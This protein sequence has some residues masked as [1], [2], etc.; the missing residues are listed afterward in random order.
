MIDAPGTRARIYLV[1]DLRV[2]VGRQSVSRADHDV[3]LPNLSFQLLLALIEAAPNVLSVDSLMAR[4][5]PGQV[6]SP[7]TINKRAKLLR[8]ALG[9]NAREPRYF[10]GVRSR[11]Y[12][13]IAPVS[14]VTDGLPESRVAHGQSAVPAIE[15]AEPVR[16]VFPQRRAARIAAAVLL[17]VCGMVSLRS[18]R[19]HHEPA[20]DA[21]ARVV[22]VS[23]L[24]FQN[25]SADADDAYFSLGVPEMI[26]SRV[27]QIRGLTVL[28]RS[29]SFAVPR[30]LSAREIGRRLN[31]RYLVT[32]S[33]QRESQRL[34][35]LV[36]LIEAESGT[37]IWS[38]RYDRRIGEIFDVEEK[39]ADQVSDALAMRNVGGGLPP[40]RQERSVNVQAYL[41]YLRGRSLLNRFTAPETEAAIPLFEQSIALDGAFAPSKAALYDA[42]MQA[43]DTQGEDLVPLRRQYNDLIEQALATDPQCG[44][45]YI[46]R[47]MWGSD[48]PH[49]RALD[50]Q[51]GLE[52]DPSNGRG[53]TA[54]AFFL[55][56]FDPDALPGEDV[57]ALQR[58]LLIDPMSAQARFLDAAW[59][60]AAGEMKSAVVEEKLLQ[61]LELDPNFVPAL[62]RYGKYR[63][64]FDG[65]IAEGLGYEEH[66]IA[67]DPKNPWSRLHAMAM[68]LDL[69]EEAAAR[70]VVAG[71]AKSAAL[72]P[73]MLALHAGDRR[74]AGLA[75]FDQSAFAHN[76]YENWGAPEALR[77]Y[78]L[79]GGEYEK[80]ISFLRQVYQMG[81]SSSIWLMTFRPALYVSQLLAAEGRH[82][83]ALELKRAVVAWNDS[84]QAKFGT[85]YARRLRAGI[86]MEEGNRVAALKELEASFRAYDYEFWWYTLE[87]DPIWQPAHDD[88][89][90]RAI[91]REVRQY[92]SLQHDEL[93]K[94][95][96][97]G[98]VPLRGH[99]SAVR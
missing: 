77:D 79:T 31:S 75:A 49:E 89:R 83:E 52:L 51:R 78:A 8:D 46:A 30:D 29:S 14:E 71:T 4:V 48:D 74:T 3:P 84:N 95:R 81:D 55:K 34:R 35:V 36:Q 96:R 27:S 60:S 24:P 18:F 9:D 43:A 26:I 10:A 62:Q 39:I 58:A 64:L 56:N 44:A 20:P 67:L 61:V 65:R 32:G 28:A 99:S 94:L 42:R 90:F 25:I 87:R 93:E 33:V 80:T 22:T 76:P 11:G 91:V 86:F 45:A 40:R 63:W 98:A 72:S 73:L 68:Y 88:P 21:S 7:E 12:R 50:F 57:R 47:A 92:V 41:A 38:A 37:V 69:G 5:W 59:S 6:V 2:D 53:T 17:M 66:A 16:P 85:V 15:A 97:S 70:E 1:D 13:L 19:M 82:A 23:V 54:Y